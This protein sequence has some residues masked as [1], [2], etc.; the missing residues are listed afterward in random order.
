MPRGPRLD[1]PEATRHTCRVAWPRPPLETLARRIGAACGIPDADLRG[2]RRARRLSAA[3]R[4][5]CQLAVRHLGYSVVA[6][7]R[8][9]GVTTS[10]VTRAAW[11]DPVPGLTKLLVP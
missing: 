3:R 1:A 4:L 7:A 5:L 2:G 6:V 9:L 10:A 8:F 11:A